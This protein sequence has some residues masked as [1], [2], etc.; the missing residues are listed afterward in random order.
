MLISENGADF[1]FLCLQNGPISPLWENQ[2]AV[3]VL[4]C[5]KHD[6]SCGFIFQNTVIVCHIVLVSC[7]GCTHRDSPQR[8]TTSGHCVRVRA[9][10]RVCV[11][12][13]IFGVRTLDVLALLEVGL[14]VFGEQR[15]AG[16]VVGATHRPVVTTHLVLPAGVR[17]MLAA[18]LFEYNFNTIV[19]QPIVPI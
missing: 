3:T 15:G 19:V 8:K 17:R 5:K 13:P 4:V 2:A 14:Q 9:C 10:V 1:L 18:C 16:R 11:Y 7:S 12:P 6:T